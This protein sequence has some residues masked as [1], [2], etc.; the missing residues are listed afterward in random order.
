MPELIIRFQREN[1]DFPSIM[2]CIINDSEARRLKKAMRM[3]KKDERL[4][5]LLSIEIK[6]YDMKSRKGFTG[7]G[8]TK[9]RR[10]KK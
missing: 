6:E 7:K 10:T 2:R 9:Q 5:D 4:F 1:T 3:Y 8:K